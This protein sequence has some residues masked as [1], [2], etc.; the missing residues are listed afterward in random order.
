MRN[1]FTNKKKECRDNSE[2]GNDSLSKP[3]TQQKQKP[4]ADQ[5]SHRQKLT[6]ITWGSTATASPL[7]TSLIT[8]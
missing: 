2:L 4:L 1:K 6:M 3:S 5:K 8:L 7:I